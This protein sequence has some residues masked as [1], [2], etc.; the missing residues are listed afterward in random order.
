MKIHHSGNSVLVGDSYRDTVAGL[1]ADLAACDLPAYPGLPVGASERRVLDD[2]RHL[3]GFGERGFDDAP[4]L[5]EASLWVAALPLLIEAQ[6]RRLHPAPPPLTLDQVKAGAL[7]AVDA[8]AEQ[9]RLAWITPGSGQALEYEMTAREAAAAAAATDPLDPEVYP[10]V[11]A[12]RSARASVGQN[13][14]LRE[15]A[16]AVAA[17]GEAWSAASAKIKRVR[18]GAKLRLETAATI[19]DVDGILTD[20]CWPIPL[21][22][23]PPSTASAPEPLSDAAQNGSGAL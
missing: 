21:L 5:A 19:A 7:A 14:T 18:R 10:H 22:A 3:V 8:A 2:G 20:I 16:T 12:E 4:P 11:E 15:V 1:T 6:R 13:L 23:P 9:A 17:E